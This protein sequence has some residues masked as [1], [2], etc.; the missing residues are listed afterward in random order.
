LAAVGGMGDT[1]EPGI[2]ADL[3]VLDEAAVDVLFNEDFD[4]LAAVGTDDVELFLVGHRFRGRT[5]A[6]VTH[7][8]Y[9]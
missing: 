1:Y 4:L 6:K 5:V 9:R 3:A 7:A 2:A 8:L